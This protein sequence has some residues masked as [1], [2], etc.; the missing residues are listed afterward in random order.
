MRTLGIDLATTNGSTGICEID[1]HRRT[2]KVEVGRFAD[3]DIVGQIRDV[4]GDGGW[5]SIDTPFGFPADFARSV[6]AWCRDGT[7]PDATDDEIRYRVSERYV[8]ERQTAFKERMGGRSTFPLSPVASL[9][10]PTIIR[11]ARI[12]TKVHDGAPL[13]RIG[14]TSRVVE[15]YPIAALRV[16][17]ITTNRY[18][19][20]A[21]D[22]R[23]IFE[24]LCHQAGVSCPEGLGAIDDDAVDAFVCAL[25]AQ[26]V[27]LADGATVDDID[28]AQLDTVREEGW[29][30]LPP[31]DHRLDAL[32]IP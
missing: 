1:W 27:A 11:C 18:K 14:L 31:R 5:I 17:R 20:V 22:C 26:V 6:H 29:I 30:H 10:T 12:L 9:I 16:W 21:A 19:K 15:A 8:A 25:V 3:D 23:M 32:A 4:R 28:A 13:D 7:V 2:S 24:K